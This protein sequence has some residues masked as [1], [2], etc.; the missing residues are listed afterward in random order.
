MYIWIGGRLP[1]TFEKEIRGALTERLEGV[2][3]DI[4]GLSLPQHI[5]L[6]ISFEAGQQYEEIL[7]YLEGLLEQEEPV[8]VAPSGVERQGGILWVTFEENQRLQQLHGILDRELE[9]RFGVGQHMFDQCFKFHSTLCMGEPEAMDR[10]QESMTEV[11]L[12]RGLEIN[13]FL[14]GV[15][16]SG[17]SGTYRVVRTVPAD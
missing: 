17:K 3:A 16:E 9:A 14:L 1:E 8:S 2:E 5:S 10:L 15:S 11:V 6:K 12:P 4:S 13:A 7:D